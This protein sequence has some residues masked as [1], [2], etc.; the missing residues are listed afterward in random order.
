[1]QNQATI[2][3][4]QSTTL[5]NMLLSATAQIVS[6]YV[7]S[8]PDEKVNLAE[9]TAQV[10]S[11]LAAEVKQ[12]TRTEASAP[13]KAEEKS[14]APKPLK[15]AVSVEDSVKPDYIICLEDGQ[16]VKMLKRY[17]NTNFQLTPEEY[18]RRW[19]LPKNYPM[20]APNY[21]KMRS[22]LA[23]EIGLGR[24]TGGRKRRAA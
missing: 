6:N 2:N 23:K 1:M 4:A 7:V 9:L 10:C 19:N 5:Q 24:K 22:K 13:K 16:R 15:P 17:L 12:L 18:R 8:R 20:V 11:T 3:D 21:A 14:Q